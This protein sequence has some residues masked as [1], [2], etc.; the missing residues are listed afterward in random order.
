MP[1]QAAFVIGSAILAVTPSK[2][3]EAGHQI[4]IPLAH[5]QT[6]WAAGHRLA[7]DGVPA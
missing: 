1:T 2:R 7:A 4:N 3:M 6:R 5:W